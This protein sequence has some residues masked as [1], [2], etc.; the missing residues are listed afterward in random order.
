MTGT[1]VFY[2]CQSSA[3]NIRGRPLED[4][5]QNKMRSKKG[6]KISNVIEQE[7]KFQLMMQGPIKL[8][9]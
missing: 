1:N 9:Y 5:K 7:K 8:I 4:W 6:K 2:C 3:K